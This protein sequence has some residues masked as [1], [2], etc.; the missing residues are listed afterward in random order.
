MAKEYDRSDTSPFLLA[1]P[2]AAAAV[3]AGWMV[4]RLNPSLG[5]S[6]YDNDRDRAQPGDRVIRVTLDADEI[7]TALDEARAH[8]YTPSWWPEVLDTPLTVWAPGDLVRVSNSYSH[9][10]WYAFGRVITDAA[11]DMVIIGTWDIERT[12]TEHDEAIAQNAKLAEVTGDD[13]PLY[14]SCLTVASAILSPWV[15][16]EVP[17]LPEPAPEPAAAE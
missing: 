2:E 16:A 15:E 3:P 12:S 8:G 4:R 13:P 10:M 11:G 6:V 17:P 1:S 14:D 9:G 7:Q 5:G